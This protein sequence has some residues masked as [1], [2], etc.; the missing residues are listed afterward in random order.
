MAKTITRGVMDFADELK[1]VQKVASI[2]F[3][4]SSGDPD[5]DCD[6]CG[7]FALFNLPGEIAIT[8]VRVAVTEAWT[9]SADC[10]IGTSDDT[11]GLLSEGAGACTVASSGLKV[12]SSDAWFTTN[13]GGVYFSSSGEVIS[14]VVSGAT[15]TAGKSKLIV[16]Y[17]LL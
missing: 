9:A 15:P 14:V 17:V 16:E 11:D 6:D 13:A 4:V 3:G 8:G 1:G 7:T 5:V 12:H 10:N 2:S